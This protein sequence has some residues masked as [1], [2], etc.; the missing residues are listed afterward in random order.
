MALCVQDIQPD[1]AGAIIP[2][3]D[4]VKNAFPPRVTGLMPVV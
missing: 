2:V 4:A 1:P 3:E